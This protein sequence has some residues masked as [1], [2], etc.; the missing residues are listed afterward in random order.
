MRG[1]GRRVASLVA[2][3]QVKTVKELIKVINV[4]TDVAESETPAAEGES[5]NLPKRRL[6][7][8]AASRRQQQAK[9][10]EANADTPAHL[11]AGRAWRLLLFAAVTNG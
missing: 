10:N 1:L 6:E 8:I 9:I 5:M 4:A 11:R 2:M 3:Y 7:I